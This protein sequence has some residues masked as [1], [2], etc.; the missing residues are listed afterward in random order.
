MSEGQVHCTLADGVA[1]VV[2][3]RPNARNAMTWAMYDGL[4]RAC[5]EIAE[6][7][8]VRVATFRGAGGEAFVAGTDIAQFTGYTADDGVRYEAHI[9]LS[10]ERMETLRKPTIAAV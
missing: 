7:P 10:I 3:D 8:E 6:N 9:A 1:A 2:F 5:R 4:A